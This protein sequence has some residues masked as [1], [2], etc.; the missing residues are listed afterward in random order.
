MDLGELTLGE[1]NTP[2]RE[3]VTLAAWAGIDH[4]YLKR[5]DLN[6]TGS[7]KDRGAVMQIAGCIERG[8]RVAVIS[9]SGNA[10]LAAATYGQRGG[11]TVVALLSPRTEPVRVVTLREAGAR[12]VITPKPINYSIRLS[13]VRGWPDLRP[14]QSADA[15]TGFRGLGAELVAELPDST[16][17]FGYASS[18]ATFQALGQVFGEGSAH[19][20]LHPVQAG[21]VNG[22]SREFGRHGDGRRSLVGDLGVKVSDRA[23]TVA[24]MA[25]QSGGQG[26]WVG[27][28]DIAAAGDVLREQRYDVGPECWAALAGLRSAAAETGV[29]TAC[30]LLTGRAVRTI[31]VPIAF[32]DPHEEL[33]PGMLERPAVTWEEVLALV[34]DLL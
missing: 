13:R 4:L 29:S 6:P 21:L 18:G 12:V 15:V 20:P 23:A 25:R 27:D 32:H 17:V 22:I 19:L 30:L 2:L 9:S 26:W 24:A 16:P 33:G 28:D 5:E 14:S 10:A 31:P 7:H 8:R 11:V 1:G 34:A 3:D